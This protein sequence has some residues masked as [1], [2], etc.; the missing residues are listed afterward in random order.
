MDVQRMNSQSP[1]FRKWTMNHLLATLAAWLTLTLPA[2]ADVERC[3]TVVGEDARNYC[4]AIATR[5]ILYCQVISEADTKN[6]C[7]AY[8][9]SERAYCQKVKDPQQ[10]KQ[11]LAVLGRSGR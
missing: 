7:M 2:L 10:Q 3:K 1:L 8:L 4:M 11:C 5:Q 6:L 9:K